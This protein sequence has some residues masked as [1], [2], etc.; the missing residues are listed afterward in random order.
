MAI[1][2]TGL[3]ILMKNIQTNNNPS[4]QF[5]DHIRLP[6]EKIDALISTKP[7][8]ILGIILIF[9]SIRALLFVAKSPP[10]LT[11]GE[12]DSWWAISLNLIHGDGYSLC[13]SKYF[14]FCSPENQL[15]AMREPAPVLFFALVAI[16]GNESLWAATFAEFVIYLS[17]PILLFFLTREWSNTRAGL[18]AAFLWALN[19]PALDLIPQVSS[20]LLAGLLVSVGILMTLRARMTQ[21]TRDWFSAAICL[22]LAVMSRSATLV[23]VIVVIAGQ[24]IDFLKKKLDRQQLF[25]SVITVTTTTVVIMAP[26]LIRNQ[27]AFGQPIIGSSLV[28]YNLY[29]HNY[30]ISTD[31]YLRYVAGAE[32]YDATRRLI[33]EH[34]AEITGTENEAKME[35]FYQKAAVDI[36]SAHPI[37]YLQLC[38][39]RIMPLWFNW[40][41]LEAYGIPTG[42]HGFIIMGIQIMFLLLACIGLTKNVWRTWPLWGSVILISCAYMA[43]DAQLLYVMPVMPLMI[44]LSAGGAERL[45]EVLSSTFNLDSH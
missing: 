44:S 15:T 31:N 23:I 33:A 40:R 14:P 36:I 8:L 18:V 39:Y 43:V 42:N 37:R 9:I 19:L 32:G 3:G 1:Q 17:I 30:L 26:W 34:A 5:G 6:L 38:A 2:G 35:S 13:L 16:M 22:G 12:T 4:K 11:S 21:R 7:L 45:L 41:V 25:R 29:R 28:G 20:D 27:I 24:C 10:A